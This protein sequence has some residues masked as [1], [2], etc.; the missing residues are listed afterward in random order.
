MRPS[1]PPVG[2]QLART[3]KTV[4]RAFNDALA[5][6]GGSLPLW[7]VLTSLKEEP[8]RTQLDLARA[9]GIEGPTLTR[10]LDGFERAG[11]VERR[12]GSDDRRA[13][14]VELTAAGERMFETLLVAVIAFN[15][16]LT[17]GLGDPELKRLQHTLARL[18]ANVHAGSP[19]TATMKT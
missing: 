17:T 7:L 18:E 6:A 8:R 11:L 2:L 16:Q 5:G 9:V 3:A 10:H 15:R 4:S 1:G 12:R 19:A 14:R 13:V